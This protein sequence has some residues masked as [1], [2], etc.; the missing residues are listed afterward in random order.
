MSA[1]QLF[2]LHPDPDAARA[3]ADRLFAMVSSALRQ[4]LPR[5]ADIRHIGATAVPGCLTKGDLDIVVRV[6]MED[7]AASDAVLAQRFARNTGSVWTDTFAAFEDATTTPH[8]G[9]QLTVID[10]PFDDFH[11]FSEALRRDASLVMAYNALKSGFAGRSMDDYRAAKD[12]FIAR[13]LSP[14]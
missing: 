11:R 13:V 5:T 9:V 14:D 6:A 12:A 4:C 3:A 8:L 10:G 7:F 2:I 1:Q